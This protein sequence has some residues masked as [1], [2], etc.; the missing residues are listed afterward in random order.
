MKLLP[1]NTFNFLSTLQLFFLQ[2]LH[3]RA[4]VGVLFHVISAIALCAVTLQRDKT[5]IK[6]RQAA[7]MSPSGGAED[8]LWS[9]MCNLRLCS[10]P[11]SSFRPQS[12]PLTCSRRCDS[13]S[14]HGPAKRK[15]FHPSTA[16]RLN[17]W[18]SRRLTGQNDQQDGPLVVT[19]IHWSPTA[20]QFSV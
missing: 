18:Q 3:C 19:I 11:A 2:Y 10:A 13:S 9:D 6:R 7:C 14:R 4:D 1:N 5:M 15:H 20:S 16:V 12:F 17:I 8:S